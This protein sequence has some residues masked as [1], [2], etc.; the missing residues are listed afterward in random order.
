MTS[1]LKGLQ[2][3]AQSEQIAKDTAA[4]LK[5]GGSVHVVKTKRFVRKP[6]NP[7]PN[8]TN[9]QLAKWAREQRKMTQ[10]DMANAM[11]CSQ[12][13]ISLVER[14]DKEPTPEWMATL[15]SKLK[16]QQEKRQ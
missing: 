6:L 3:Q 15:A 16:I 8:L 4:F 14:G 5:A 12:G 7:P 1:H 9:G 2:K 11:D 10:I 13:Y